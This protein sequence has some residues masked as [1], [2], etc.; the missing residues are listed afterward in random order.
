[1]FLVAVPKGPTSFTNVLHSA[2]QMVILISVNN[3]SFVGDVILVLGA[4]NRSLIVLL[5]LKWI[6]IPAL[7]HMSLKLSLSPL[8]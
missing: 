6:W 1:M 8:E 2:S 5:P 3:T 7:P 4:T